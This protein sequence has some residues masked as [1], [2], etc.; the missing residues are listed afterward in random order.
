MST[1]VIARVNR[2]IEVL[3]GSGEMHYAV[4]ALKAGYSPEYFRRAI[5]PLV[6]ELYECIHY[7][8]INKVLSWICDD[9]DEQ[10]Q[11]HVVVTR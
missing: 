8:R 6:L 5:L 4:F 11:E 10:Q 3:K 7:D 9:E 1:R 2:A